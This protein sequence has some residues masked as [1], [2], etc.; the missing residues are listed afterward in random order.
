MRHEQRVVATEC[1]GVHRRLPTGLLQL[2]PIVPIGQH[3]YTDVDGHKRVC[4]SGRIRSNTACTS[5]RRATTIL[6]RVVRTRPVMQGRSGVQ[7]INMRVPGQLWSGV[8]DC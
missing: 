1:V 7:R 2:R 8:V 6:Q 4:M 5:V 3:L